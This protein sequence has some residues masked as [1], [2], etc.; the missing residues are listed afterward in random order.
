MIVQTA[1]F[2]ISS[3]LIIMAIQF[4]ICAAQLCFRP[5]A[6]K[7]DLCHHILAW[8]KIPLG[9]GTYS[10]PKKIYC[11]VLLFENL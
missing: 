10:M 6:L 8:A 2:L 5:L 7:A 9:P 1:S 4:M 11:V 3:V